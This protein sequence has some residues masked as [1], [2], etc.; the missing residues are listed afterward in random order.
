MIEGEELV[1]AV[2]VGREET[3]AGRGLFLA[4]GLVIRVDDEDVGAGEEVAALGEA[5]L[6]ARERLATLRAR[7]RRWGLRVVVV[8]RGAG[9]EHAKQK[10]GES[11]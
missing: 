6:F 5:F 10:H 1:G 2:S 8:G 9:G 4:C 7:G 3:D 11:M